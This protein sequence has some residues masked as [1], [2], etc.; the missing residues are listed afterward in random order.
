MPDAN[1]NPL[2]GEDGYVAFTE[3]QNNTVTPPIETPVPDTVPDA[4]VIE[5]EVVT[6]P[7]IDPI[8]EQ[9]DS[10]IPGNISPDTVAETVSKEAYDRLLTVFEYLLVRENVDIQLQHQYRA[11]AGLV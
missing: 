1:N 8:V 9:E 2:P 6:P 5:P 7:V 3:E 10:T 11:D 4:S